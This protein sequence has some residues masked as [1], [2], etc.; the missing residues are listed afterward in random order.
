MVSAN[1]HENC[2]SERPRTRFENGVVFSYE[3]VWLFWHCRVGV[4]ASLYR[5]S[6]RQGSLVARVLTCCLTFVDFRQVV[7]NKSHRGP[8]TCRAARVHQ[9]LNLANEFPA[10]ECQPPTN[11]RLRLRAFWCPRLYV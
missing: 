2:E 6:F 1:F 11:R 9:R 10:N 8:C 5:A 3:R 4:V 7:G